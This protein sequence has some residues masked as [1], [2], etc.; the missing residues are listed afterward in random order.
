MPYFQS[1]SQGLQQALVQGSCAS[2]Y[3]PL[4]DQ[5]LS[6]GT[7]VAGMERKCLARM[8]SVGYSDLWLFHHWS[9]SLASSGVTLAAKYFDTSS[10]GVLL[11]DFLVFSNHLVLA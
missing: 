3:L 6:I 4:F 8:N 10:C 2:W 7:E 1:R 11:V 9:G 5:T